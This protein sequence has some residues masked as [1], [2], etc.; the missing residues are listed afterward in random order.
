MNFAPCGRQMNTAC[1]SRTLA[2]QQVEVA[3]RAK[4]LETRLPCGDDGVGIIAALESGHGVGVSDK[5]GGSLQL[6]LG[7]IKRVERA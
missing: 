7:W 2:V 6:K 5:T 1:L 3:A 4:G